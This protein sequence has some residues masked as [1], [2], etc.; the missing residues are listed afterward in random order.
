M[1]ERQAGGNARYLRRCHRIASVAMRCDAQRKCRGSHNRACTSR[2]CQVEQGGGFSSLTHMS[3]LC[4]LE[5]TALQLQL[6]RAPASAA[7]PSRPQ[8]RSLVL[9]LRTDPVCFGCVRDV[10]VLRSAAM[11]RHCIAGAGVRT[12]SALS[13]RS[14]HQPRPAEVRSTG[15]GRVQA[16]TRRSS[17]IALSS[18]FEPTWIADGCTCH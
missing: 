15:R 6:N 8:R 1:G 2:C 16:S 9:L 4:A 18:S 10:C 3:L 12:A 7:L 14:L 5:W 17:T 11:D 13:R